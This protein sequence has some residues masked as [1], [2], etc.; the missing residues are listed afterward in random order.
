MP[1]FSTDVLSS[2][3]TTTIDNN[4]HNNKNHNG[5]NLE[6]TEPVLNFSVC[7]YRDQV[8][9]DENDPENETQS[10]AGKIVGPVLKN[11]LQSNQIRGR[12]NSIVK[13]VIPS[14]SESKSIVHKTSV[15]ISQ[16][17]TRKS[18]WLTLQK[19][20]NFPQRE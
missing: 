18:V 6:Q 12:G 9:S 10:P 4:A 1:I 3:I 7:S 2:R 20:K 13:P 5:D 17:F 15:Q 19:Y 11:D 14:K 8:D 16:R